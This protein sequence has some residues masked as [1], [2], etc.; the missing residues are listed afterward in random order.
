MHWNTGIRALF[1]AFFFNAFSKDGL[2]FL[3]F[4]SGASFC[5][6]HFSRSGS[7]GMVIV[8][9]LRMVVEFLV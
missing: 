8:C 1:F 4:E 7:H 9:S 2:T 3:P 5:Y 6:F